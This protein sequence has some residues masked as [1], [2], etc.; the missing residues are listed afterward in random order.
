MFRQSSYERELA[1]I[2]R[3]MQLLE[4]RLDRLGNVATR[5][6]ASGFASAAQATDRVGDAIVSALGEVVDRFRGGA[7]TAGGEAA[8]LG[9]EAR[10]LGNDA[11]RR[12]STE[13]EHRP[14]IT[15]AI[16]A[17]IGILIGLAGRR[18]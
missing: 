18:S 13:I 1:A 4:R 16:V 6:A 15:L 11:L 2:E 10:K 3:R 7:R 12:V 8:R 17:G 9:Y 14:L 5:T